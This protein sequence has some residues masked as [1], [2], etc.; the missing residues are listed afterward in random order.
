MASVFI[1]KF[2]KPHW[3]VLAFSLAALIVSVQLYLL[4][5][6]SFWGGIYTRYNNYVIFKQ[7]FFHLLEHKNLYVQYP[8]EYGDF[9][10]YSPTFALLFAPFSILPTLS[11]LIAWNLLNV[12]MLVFALLKLPGLKHPENYWIPLIIAIELIT[13]SQS[14]QSN[15][16]IAGIMIMGFTLVKKEK[17]FGAAMLISLGTFIKIYCILGFL[18]FFFAPNKKKFFFSGVVA[19]ATLLMLPALLIGFSELTWQYKN[20]GTLLTWDMNDSVGSS[21]YGISYV[22]TGSTRFKLALQVTGIVLLI[23]PLLFISIHDEKK[24]LQYLAYVLMWMVLFNHKAES[25]TFIIAF[26]GAAIWF[27][28]TKR[29]YITVALFILCFTFC[30][31]SQTD[32]FP[33]TLRAE[34]ITYHVKAWPFVFVFAACL[35]DLLKKKTIVAV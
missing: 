27:F 20:W 10:K 34:F 26:T 6:G 7:S 19:M 16:L 30:C 31:L 15:A 22:M 24:Q 17:Y 8:A 32:L 14:C 28:T 18:V 12:F 29:N 23:V 35:M 4:P 25:A 33:K 21:V 2:F 11:G 13:S 3:F 1:N 9:F 5:P